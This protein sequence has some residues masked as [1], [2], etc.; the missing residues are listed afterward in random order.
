M[1]VPK[2]KRIAFFV[3]KLLG[4]PRNFEIGLRDPGHAHLGV[5]FMNCTQG[6]SAL[7]V[8]TK[9]QADSFFPSNVIRVPKYEIG[10]RD[11]KPRPF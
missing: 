3:R 5:F 9:F 8:C 2:F 6:E 1:S 11:P 4:G 7:Y 10:S